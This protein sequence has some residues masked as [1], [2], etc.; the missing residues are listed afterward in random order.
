MHR[1]AYYDWEHS[2]KDFGTKIQSR[3]KKKLRQVEYATVG[4]AKIYFINI[5]LENSPGFCSF[6]CESKTWGQ[7]TPAEL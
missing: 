3:D 2:S 1:G 4:L 6:P 5:L 7:L